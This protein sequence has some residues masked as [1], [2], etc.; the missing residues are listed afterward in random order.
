[1]AEKEEGTARPF[2]KALVYERDGDLNLTWLFVFLMGLV[3]SLGFMSTVIFSPEASVL[4][5]IAAWSF[6]GG[7]FMAVLIAAVPIAKAK[8]L[9]QSSLPADF[10]K[11]IASVAQNVEQSTDVQEIFMRSQQNVPDLDEVG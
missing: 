8:I 7:A 9:A 11:G 3:G 1:M 10:A 5:K 4:E 2:L 6:L